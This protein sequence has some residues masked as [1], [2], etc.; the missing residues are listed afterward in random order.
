MHPIDFS[1]IRPQ[2]GTQHGGFEELS[3]SLFR[4][5]VGEPSKFIRVEG[6]G[7]DGGV[8]AFTGSGKITGLQAKFFGKLGPSQWQQMKKSLLSA[9]KSHPRLTTYYFAVPLDRTPAATKQWQA[10]RRTAQQMNPPVKL[11]WWG[12][13]EII[14][15]LSRTEHAGR[16]AYWFGTPQF[17]TDWL[18]RHNA[19]TRLDLD[20]RYTPDQ[21]VEVHAQR[22]LQ[23]F[24]HAPNSIKRYYAL[25]GDLWKAWRAAVDLH[26]PEQYSKNVAKAVSD[27]VAIGV[28]ELPRLGDGKKLPV[29]SDARAA[30][31]QL[32]DAVRRI[33]TDLMA[34]A[35]V[36]R[37]KNAAPST[38]RDDRPNHHHHYLDKGLSAIN[39]LNGFLQ[40]FG[41]FDQRLLLLTGAAG[42]GKSHV[43]ARFIEEMKSREQPALF[44][45]G[46]YFTAGSEPWG[47]LVAKLGWTGSADQLLAALNH[48]AEARGAPAVIAI[49]ALNESVHRE[50]WL[51]HLRSFAAGLAPWPWV[52]LVVSCRSDFVP[53]TVPQAIAEHRDPT[54]GYA[55]H[56]GFEEETFT[57]VSR[58]FSSY[59]IRVRDFPPLLP[60]FGN[61]LFLKTFAEAF[62]NDEIPTGSLTLDRVMQQRLAVTAR[63]IQRAIDC[64]EDTTRAALDTFAESVRLNRWQPLPIAT[65]RSVIDARLPGRGES[66]SLFHHLRSSGLITE[67]GYYD[68]ATNRT[69]ARIRFAYERFSDYFVAVRLL[70]DHKD[71][72]ALQEHWAKEGFIVQWNS[73]GGYYSNR[74]LLRSLSILLPERFGIELADVITD[75]SVERILLEDFLESLAWRSPASITEHSRNVRRRA[76]KADAGANLATLMRL[77]PIVGHPWNADHLHELLIKIPLAER[78]R[79]WT[80]P[81]SNLLRNE[82]HP[83]PK[84]I[85]RWLFTARLDLI[86]DE[87]ARLLGKLLGWFFSSNDRGFRRRATLAATRLLQ[88]RASVVARLIDDFHLVDDG[89][90]L[91]RVLAVAAGV[92]IREKD[93]KKLATLAVAVWKRIFAPK[94]VRPHILI[95]D[96]ANTVMSIAHARGCLPPGVTKKDFKPPYRSNWPT[97]WSNDESRAFGKTE[98]WGQIVHS[99]EPEHAVGMYGDF[100]RYTMQYQ[101]GSWMNVRRTKPRPP[102]GEQKGFD[103]LVA[104]AW[105]LQRVKELGWTPERFAEYEKRVPYG[106]QSPDIEETKQERISKKYQWIALHELEAYL[107][108]HYHL[109]ERWTDAPV[110]FES[111]DQLHT[112]D[113]D[114]GQ[115]LRDPSEPSTPVDNAEPQWWN[116]YPDPFA[117]TTL[118]ADRSAWAIHRPDDFAPLIDVGR[119]PELGLDTVALAVWPTWDEPVPYPP[120]PPGRG[121]PHQWVHLRAWLVPRSLRAPWLKRLRQMHFYGD[122]VGLPS[123]GEIGLGDYPSAARFDSIREACTN[124]ERFGGPIPPG[125]THACCI[126]GDWNACIPS[127]QLMDLL[128]LTWR[129]HDFDFDDN[130]GR[131]IAYSPPRVEKG[132]TPPCLVAKDALV[133]ALKKAGLAIIWGA[134]GERTCFDHEIS[135][136]VAKIAPE[137]SAIYTMDDHGNV[138]GGLTQFVLERFQPRRAKAKPASRTKT[139]RGAKKK[140]PRR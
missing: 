89:Y 63:Q 42:T 100:G 69:D 45:L 56:N 58:Y 94:K 43:L 3:V 81:V 114:P 125:L 86:S 24:S 105:V 87:Q 119:S 74:G 9:R 78:D 126:Y 53:L 124:Q 120:P 13:S 37:T 59:N 115:P 76:A 97:I 107:A 91:E 39:H 41:C 73:L 29:L 46:E 85:L 62:E 103:T 55:D 130:S 23:A 49:D 6:A 68:H 4:R 71:A 77:A 18:D 106:R 116:R 129:G 17:T 137:F 25:A 140:S 38:Q 60:E 80:I 50:V 12:A 15:F 128:G 32:S 14:D 47:Q 51:S 40:E 67:V 20:T 136:H 98:G 33:D 19:Q 66:K 65:A 83:T 93:P 82:D 111:A 75:K 11:V 36:I 110:E 64:P 109:R 132:G 121:K 108:D 54:W 22:V 96:Y 52:R 21:H 90:V 70:H 134:V 8:E 30:L 117:D 5:E 34:A 113:F 35:K 48:A 88:G 72:S 133:A 57:A 2:R 31:V 101:I 61:A 44:L 104:R 135:E 99:I 16:A 139:K 127:P 10:L 27:S 102:N 138:T 26:K 7:G 122:G 131:I 28:R 123:L 112:R 118:T 84:T 92:A 79:G 1:R 95:R